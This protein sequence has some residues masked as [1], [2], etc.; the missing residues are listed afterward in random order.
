M[1]S[2]AGNFMIMAATETLGEAFATALAQGLS[3]S[4]WAIIARM[5]R[6]EA[7]L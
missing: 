4:D 7:G 3:E 1:K 6:K 5:S 2:L